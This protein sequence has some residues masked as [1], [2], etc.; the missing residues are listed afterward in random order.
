MVLSFY[1]GL[2]IDL[3]LSA[4]WQVSFPANPFSNLDWLPQLLSPVVP[5]RDAE[6]A[7]HELQCTEKMLC[8]SQPDCELPSIKQ[9]LQSMRR[10]GKHLNGFQTS[11]PQFPQGTELYLSCLDQFFWIQQGWGTH[12][13]HWMTQICLVFEGSLQGLLVM[14]PR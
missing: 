6:S 2:G 1:H 10:K 12:W 3:R 7:R 5:T 11:V 9:S 14:H 4:C 13:Q 8:C